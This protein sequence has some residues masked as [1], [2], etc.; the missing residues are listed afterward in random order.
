MAK[1]PTEVGIDK[2][3]E[4]SLRDAAAKV[5]ATAPWRTP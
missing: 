2:I 5:T 3:R 4:L 1:L